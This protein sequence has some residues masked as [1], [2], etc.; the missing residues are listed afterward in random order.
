M[1]AGSYAAA[2]IQWRRG[3]AA[4]VDRADGIPLYAVETVRMLIAEGRLVAED[5]RY[6]PTGTSLDIL[7]VPPTSGSR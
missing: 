7:S 5:G 2:P 3:T 1:I 4:I 6:S